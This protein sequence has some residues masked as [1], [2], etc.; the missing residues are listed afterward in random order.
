VRHAGQ[1]EDDRVVRDVHKLDRHP[2]DVEAVGAQLLE[3]LPPAEAN[4]DV[5]ADQADPLVGG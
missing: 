2:A 5:V 1:A 3:A 4:V